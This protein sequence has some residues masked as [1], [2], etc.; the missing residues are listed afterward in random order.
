MRLVEILEAESRHCAWAKWP[1]F[2]L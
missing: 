1:L 2:L